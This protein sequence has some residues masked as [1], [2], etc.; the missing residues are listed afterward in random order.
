MNDIFIINKKIIK[1]RKR[2]RRILNKLQEIELQVKQNKCKFE[3]L[4]IE[5]LGR[6]INKK[7]MRSSPKYLQIIRE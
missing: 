4:K 1:Y 2:I 5:I 7:E 6:I 3:K